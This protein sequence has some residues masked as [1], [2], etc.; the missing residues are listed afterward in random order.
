[1]AAGIGVARPRVDPDYNSSP[2][3]VNRSQRPAAMPHRRRDGNAARTPSN[4]ALGGGSASFE[5][6]RAAHA[7]PDLGVLPEAGQLIVGV[8][9]STD[10]QVDSAGDSCRACAPHR[11]PLRG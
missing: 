11:T 10:Q 6:D 8:G 9:A 2:V 3:T 5:E 4:P 1:M 7:D